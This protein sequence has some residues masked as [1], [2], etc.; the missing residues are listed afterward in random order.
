MSL[1]C[2]ENLNGAGSETAHLQDFF[3]SVISVPILGKRRDPCESVLDGVR[4]GFTD[5]ASLIHRTKGEAVAT[6]CTFFG[7]VVSLRVLVWKPFCSRFSEYPQKYG[8]SRCLRYMG[9]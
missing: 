3:M 4:S 2:R 6:C 5:G 1:T 9:V 8:F 7:L